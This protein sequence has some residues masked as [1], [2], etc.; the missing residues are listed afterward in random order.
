MLH[1]PDAFVKKLDGLFAQNLY[2]HGNEPSHHIAYLYDDA[3]AAWKTQMRVHQI[4]T[5]LYKNSEDGLIGNDDAGQMSAWYVMSALGFYPVTPGT[6]RY[7]I[8]TPHFDD[9][10]L[11]AGSG[12]TLHIVAHGAETGKMY[13]ASVHLNGV[14]LHRTYLLHSEVI[15]GGELVFE[16]SDVPKPLP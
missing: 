14:L 3:G 13:I 2:D 16:M 6:P 4:M 10:T 5:T 7:S 1:G 11:K 9:V 12:K 8:G 15:G